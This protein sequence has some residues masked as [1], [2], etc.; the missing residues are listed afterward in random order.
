VRN[1]PGEVLDEGTREGCTFNLPMF[2][3]SFS[4]SGVFDGPLDSFDHN[5]HRRKPGSLRQRRHP[6]AGEHALSNR[7]TFFDMSEKYFLQM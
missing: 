5:R 4:I 3:T 6:R 2:H 1:A 7:R